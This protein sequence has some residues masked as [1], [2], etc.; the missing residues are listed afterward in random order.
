M[1]EYAFRIGAVVCALSASVVFAANIAVAQVGDA[2]SIERRLTAPG[3]LP[4]FEITPEES[5]LTGKD[6]LVILKRRDFF[7]LNA[8]IAPNFT[9]NAFLS[10]A[11][12]HSDI[13]L[14]SAASIRAATVIDQRYSVSADAGLST[15]RHRNLSQLNYDTFSAG[16]GG[17]VRSEQWTYSLSYRFIYVSRP[18]GF[19][20][21]IV[22]QNNIAGSVSYRF[23][24]DDD[25]A[26]FPSLSLS[27]IWADPKDFNNV[28]LT[29]GVSFVRRITPDLLLSSAVQL[30]ARRYDD[31]FEAATLE[32]RRDFGAN[33]TIGLRWT[34][35]ANITVLGGVGFGLVNSSIDS[36]DY[37]NYSATPSIS[38]QFSF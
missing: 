25:T 9:S 2:P 5:I 21:H 23:D 14:N 4:S 1:K 20:E 10:D 13:V 18:G 11:N 3:G 16:F 31:F 30:S 37:K 8:N 17:S 12:K 33:T 15:A 19:N 35:R 6:D 38:A 32:N 24:I 26:I 34:P 22:T 7:T 28:S 36:V 29:P 27:R